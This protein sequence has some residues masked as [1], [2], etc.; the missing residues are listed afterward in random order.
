MNAHPCIDVS[1]NL[2]A[3]TPIAIARNIQMVVYC[4]PT[5]EGKLETDRH[6]KYSHRS[7][8]T[9]SYTHLQSVIIQIPERRGDGAVF[10]L[11]AAD[12][13]LGPH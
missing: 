12:N 5:S 2:H 10:E 3:A 7:I 4:Y 11:A 9:S 6:P 1:T 8:Q 13:A